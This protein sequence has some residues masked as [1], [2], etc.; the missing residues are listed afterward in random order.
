MSGLKTRQS[1]IL[2]VPHGRQT[3]LFELPSD[4]SSLTEEYDSILFIYDERI[5]NLDSANKIVKSLNLANKAVHKKIVTINNKDKNSSLLIEVL[6]AMSDAQLSRSSLI[7]AVGGGAT[8]D[9]VG[10]A[11]AMY[12]RGIDYA[13][14]PTSYISVAD[15]IVSKIAVNHRQTKNMIGAFRS[16]RWSLAT[17]ELLS[18][19]SFEQITQG[20]VEVWKHAL[21]ERDEN[22]ESQVA[23]ILHQEYA[24]SLQLSDLARWS[25][26]TKSK[27]VLPD[28]DDT[29]S[30][31][32]A[33]S[34]GHTVA[35]FLEMNDLLHHAE[36]VAHG[37]LLEAIIA[38]NRKLLLVKD[39]ESIRSAAMLFN[40]Y[41]DVFE[42][43]SRLLLS[44]ELYIALSRDK[45]SSHNSVRFVLPTS[46]GFA[47]SE[48]S[49]KEI[50][51]AVKQFASLDMS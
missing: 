10:T 32:K 7:V 21:I 3:I 46:T 28:W 29:K 4:T 1:L 9:L 27:Y 45:I 20:L 42:N 12:M 5:L 16:P 2:T 47:V 37:I 36:A 40:S 8:A 31:H 24:S 26:N 19:F 38:K 35:N 49:K 44:E 33:L 34:L 22:I 13:V 15:G 43:V 6:D 11:A 50:Q 23:T 14:I 18:S 39:F 51:A 17:S 30:I 41:F 48:V 25:M